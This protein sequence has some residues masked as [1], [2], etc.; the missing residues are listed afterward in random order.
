[1]LTLSRVN[2]DSR[3]PRFAILAGVF[4]VTRIYAESGRP[5]NGPVV[6]MFRLMTGQPCPFCGTTRSIASASLGHFDQAL[7]EN[8]VGLVVTVAMAV[9]FISPNLSHSFSAKFDQ[10]RTQIGNQAFLLLVAGLF[11]LTWLWNLTRWT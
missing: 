11:A 3:F 5:W 1:M 2:L 8:S 4:L 6:C 10:V 7:Q 9:A